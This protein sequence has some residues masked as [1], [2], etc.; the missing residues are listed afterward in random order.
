MR[1]LTRSLTVRLLLLALVWLAAA[2][3]V[4]GYVLS[5]AFRDYVVSDFD[6]R[7]SEI[8]DHM[9]G[10]SALDQGMLRFTRPIADQRFSEPYSGW[11][12]QVDVE[13]QPPFRSRSLWDQMLEPDLPAT[14]DSGTVTETAG[15]EGQRLR[16]MARDVVLPDSDQTFRYMVAGDTAQIRTDIRAFD[17][18]I[19][20]ALGVLGAGLLL[21]VVL[22]IW[23]GLLPLKAVRRG[24][25]AIRSGRARRLEGEFPTEIA[26]LVEEINALIAAN[27]RV[28]ER[29]RTHV[30]NLAHA[31]KTPL[32]VLRNEAA[33]EDGRLAQAVRTQTEII[34]RHIDHHL[35]RARASG[36]GRVGA[37]VPLERPI[38]ELVRAMRKIYA[39]RELEFAVDIAP[40]LAVRG[41]EQDLTEM[42][43]NL[44]DNACKWARH[45]VEVSARRIMEA[46]RPWV[47]I[48][49]ADDGPGVSEEEIEALFERGRRLDESK[50][51]SGLGLAIVHDVAELSGGEIRL[52]RAPAGGLAAILILPITE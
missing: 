49:I 4:G 45:R 1:Q 24:L 10:A 52:E 29:A 22:Q 13:D 36:G 44:L 34:S 48:R 41:E 23:I 7:L 50:P 38:T 30:G 12:W 42:V 27:E 2:L 6:A 9:V 31:L 28:V 3:S 32:T 14:L 25:T 33:R 11:Y 18:L 51:G 46:G 39:A 47:E 40:R 20:I 16:L 26:P 37:A 21:A 17:R 19:V 35:K 8:L 5:L 43:G 15:P